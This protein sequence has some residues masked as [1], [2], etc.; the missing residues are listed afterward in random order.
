MNKTT[1]L[2]IANDRLSVEEKDMIYDQYR[3]S[4]QTNTVLC[5]TFDTNHTKDLI[6]FKDKFICLKCL[7]LLDEERYQTMVYRGLINPSDNNIY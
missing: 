5:C 1:D 2:S 6:K 7:S 3:D 4:E